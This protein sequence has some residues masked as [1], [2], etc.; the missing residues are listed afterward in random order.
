LLQYG[1]NYVFITQGKEGGY[2]FGE[3]V[4]AHIP[5]PKIPPSDEK[6]ATGCG[7]QVTAT[8][9]AALLKDYKIRKA[10]ELAIKAGTLQFN[11]PG[12][13]PATSVEVFNN[14]V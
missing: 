6:D 14:P 8:L 4:S 5:A 2:L 10:A 13:D 9:A 1:V 3:H 11:R 12:I 7:D